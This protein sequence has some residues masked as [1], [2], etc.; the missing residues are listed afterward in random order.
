MQSW[1]A[2]DGRHLWSAHLGQHVADV[3]HNLK[4][5]PRIAVLVYG[6][7]ERLVDDVPNADLE[8]SILQVHFSSLIQLASNYSEGHSLS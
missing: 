3:G 8:S 7:E 1:K 2:E 6:A 4:K 5:L